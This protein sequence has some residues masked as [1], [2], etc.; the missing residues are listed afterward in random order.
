M[1]K[2]TKKHFKEI[3]KTLDLIGNTTNMS[4]EE[5]NKVLE[6]RVSKDLKKNYR[7]FQT[8][9]NYDIINQGDMVKT[10]VWKTFYNDFT[11]YIIFT[12]IDN[13]LNTQC[14]WD[15]LETDAIIYVV[16]K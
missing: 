9:G 12:N 7:V 1:E 5:I 8:S 4:L 6:T 10:E 2:V 14:S 15:T 3:Y 16:R 11:F 13:S